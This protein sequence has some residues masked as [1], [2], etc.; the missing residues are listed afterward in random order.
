M[1]LAVVPWNDFA[2]V[3]H[4]GVSKQDDS[5]PRMTAYNVPKKRF[6]EHILTESKAV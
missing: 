6:G 4:D 5:H 3:S 1:D 2:K